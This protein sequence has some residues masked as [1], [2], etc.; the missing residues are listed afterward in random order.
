MLPE[1]ERGAKV[2]PRRISDSHTMTYDLAIVGTGAAGLS[3]ALYAGSYKMKAV[4]FGSDFGGYTSIA[5]C[6]ENYPGVPNI[7][8]FDLMLNMKGQATAV[9]A[10][11][12]DEKI[13]SIKHEPDGFV[14]TTGQGKVVMAKTVIL[15][16]GTE[17]RHLGLPN[18]KE[19]TSKGV[20]FCAVCDAPMYRDKVIA[21]VGG[22]DAAIKGVNLAAEYAKKI[23][24]L[25]RGTALRA[26]PVNYEQMK[27]FG[28]KIEVLF[29]TEVKEIIGPEKFEKI[30]LSKPYNGSNELVLDGLFIEVGALPRNELAKQ[31]GIELDTQGYIKAHPLMQTNVPG[32]YSAGDVTN[33][34]SGFKQDITAAAMGA[35]AATSAFNFFKATYPQIQ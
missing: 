10:E 13:E 3:A 29:E 4:V 18:E 5:G 27:A 14:L 32:V 33:I 12:I 21:V 11:I 26:E 9:G 15:A 16:T 8:G 30:I 28:D 6:I 1:K 2:L 22:G 20:H 17:H 23:Y 31:L 24:V 34:F 35:V 7:D 25:V 19:L